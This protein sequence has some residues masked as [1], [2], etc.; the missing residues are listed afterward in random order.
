[1]PTTLKIWQDLNESFLLD[2]GI[3]IKQHKGKWSKTKESAIAIKTS[4]A[5]LRQW[6]ASLQEPWLKNLWECFRCDVRLKS[7][8][9][10]HYSSNVM[11]IQSSLF[12]RKYNKSP[13]II[14]NQN[15]IT[16]KYNLETL[17][18]DEGLKAII[19]ALANMEQLEILWLNEN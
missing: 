4:F 6:A 14:S 10:I 2:D 15:P 7:L 5:V 19:P 3:C 18:R 16:L 1:M 12:W 11:K 17:S 13:I 8:I 9:K